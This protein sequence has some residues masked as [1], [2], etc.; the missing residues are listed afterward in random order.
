MPKS[1]K[2]IVM[3]M[4]SLEA[5][6]K[7][8]TN[9]LSIANQPGVVPADVIEV[10]QTDAGITGKV[11]K[12]CNSAYYGFQR[13]VG[14]LQEAGNMLGTDTLVNLVL[15]SS[16]NKFFRNA[17]Q[18]APQRQE[19][20]WT[21]SIT[22]A[23]ASRLIAQKAGYENPDRAYTAG[24]M[25]NIGTIVMD[26]FYTDELGHVIAE[27]EA[28]R[29]ALA[30]ERAVLGIH[31]AEIGARLATKWELPESLTDTIRFHHDPASATVDPMLASTVH[32]AETMLGVHGED[33]LAP[34]AAHEVCE[35]AFELTGLGP[36]DFELLETMLLDELRKAQDLF[37]A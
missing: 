19:E 13:E 17:G 36:E 2:N 31:H 23:L 32:L 24:L 5:F 35:A 15:T 12:L 4:R 3:D 28:G 6:P 14:S 8:A 33:G 11:L 29:S 20:L 37:T 18:V 1:L 21:S 22:Q 9:V 16:A 10:V 30:A 27:V 7:V 34:P 26:R 25:Q